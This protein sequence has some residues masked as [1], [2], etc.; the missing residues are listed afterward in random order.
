MN[1]TRASG[2]RERALARPRF[3]PKLVFLL[4]LAAFALGAC[5]PVLDDAVSDLGP[6]TPG[7]RT[8]PLHRP[9]QPC[10]LCHDGA[11]GDPQAFSVA[12]TIYQIPSSLEPAVGAT[13]AMTDATGSTR[14]EVTNAAGN[15]YIAASDWA[16]QFPLQVQ[17]QP[18]TGPVVYM[19]SL[20]N[21]GTDVAGGACAT[22]HRDPAGADSPGHV[23]ISLDDGGV[24]R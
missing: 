7:V 6:E 3:C 24:P 22:C 19:Y 18:V 2:K 5:D 17:V 12:G 13:V 8:G 1:A 15:F 16:P 20:V 9:G 23:S 21:S 4:I 10:L 11:F 14:D